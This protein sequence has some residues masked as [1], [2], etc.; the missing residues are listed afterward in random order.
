MY[1]ELEKLVGSLDGGDPS[2]VSKL[3]QVKDEDDAEVEV[4]ESQ[5][6][7]IQSQ[8]VG[9]KYANLGQLIPEHILKCLSTFTPEQQAFL[10][11]K[12]LRENQGVSFLDLVE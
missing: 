9:M 10:R 5:L 6:R 8:I 3:K 2:E 4:S 12:Y 11:D 1:A 7:Q